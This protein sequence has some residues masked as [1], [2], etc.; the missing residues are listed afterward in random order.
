[1]NAKEIVDKPKP[2]GRPRSVRPRVVR[3]SAFKSPGDGEG[4]ALPVVDAEEVVVASPPSEEAPDPLP[5]HY[6]TAMRATACVLF[7]AGMMYAIV[8]RAIAQ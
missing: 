8:Y 5:A 7:T 2:A 1:M 6:M 4:E 3:K